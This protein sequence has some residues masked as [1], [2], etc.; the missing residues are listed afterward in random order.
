MLPYSE[1]RTLYER[2]DLSSDWDSEINK[3]LLN[4]MPS[5]Y[6]HATDVSG[7]ETR[8]H[9]ITDPDAVFRVPEEDPRQRGPSIRSIRDGTS[10]TLLLIEAGPETAAPWTHP[11]AIKF[12]EQEPLRT[13]GTLPPT[14]FP[15]AMADGSV[16]WLTPDIDPE[17][18]KSMVLK[19]DGQ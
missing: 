10:R 13:L 15:A 14:G 19:N 6:R 18:F 17:V 5:Q 1:Q 16:R 12:D 9:V 2:Y 7:D 11:S 3:R 4:S 8:V